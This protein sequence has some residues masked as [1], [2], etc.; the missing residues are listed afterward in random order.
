LLH[1]HHHHHHHLLSVA[2]TI[3]QTAAAVPSG[4]SLTPREKITGMLGSITA[5]FWLGCRNSE[6]KRMIWSLQ[7]IRTI[8]SLLKMANLKKKYIVTDLISAL[9]GNSY[10]NTVQHATIDEV[11][12]SVSAVTSHKSGQ[13]PRDVFSVDPTDAPTDWLD[14]DHVICVHCRSR[15][16]PRLYKY[17]VTEFVHGSYG[18]RITSQS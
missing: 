3:R 15:S 5:L 8:H 18:L 13:R 2:G 12:F 1:N 7:S 9:P 14:S 6:R 16:V 17:Q 11:V 4:L 10:V